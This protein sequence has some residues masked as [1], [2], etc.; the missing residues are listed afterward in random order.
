MQGQDAQQ[1]PLGTL[2]DRLLRRAGD[3][4][5]SVDGMLDAAGGA[6]YGPVLLLIA[7]VTITPVG[8]IPGVSIVTGLLLVVLGLQMLIRGGSLWVPGWIE[9]RSLDAGRVR[10]ALRK[11]R[12]VLDRIDR[13]P[14]PR[15]PQ[16]LNGPWARATAA[17]VAVM[18]LLMFPLALVPWG[19]TAPGV[20]LLLAGLGL[21]GRDGLLLAL[22]LAAMAATCALAVYATM[23]IWGG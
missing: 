4:R 21:M 13:L 8:A 7:L 17:G 12:P 23:S 18:G 5:L 22:S 11:S 16:L 2:A 19:V 3:D 14:R 15:M 10:K 6:A 9:R 20:A 1:A